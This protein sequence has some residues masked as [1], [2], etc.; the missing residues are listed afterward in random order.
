MIDL[1]PPVSAYF[2]AD[3]ASAEQ[4]AH[5]FTETAVVK[6]EGHRHVGRDAIRA[7]K[8][9]ASRKYNYVST[10]IAVATENERTVVI[11]H[12][13]GDFPGSPVNLRYFF[14]LEGDKIAE[15]E[16]TV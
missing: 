13:A 16:I 6:D 8:D 5:C 9:H 12:V 4:L 1:P 3:A 11:S 15:L 2:A 7:W 14:L 10:P